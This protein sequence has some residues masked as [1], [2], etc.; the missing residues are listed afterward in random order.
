MTT[1]HKGGEQNGK[2]Q[3]DFGTAGPRRYGSV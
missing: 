3:Q 1:S 2:K